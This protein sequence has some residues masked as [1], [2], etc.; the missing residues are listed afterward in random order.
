MGG[1]RWQDFTE[2]QNYVGSCIQSCKTSNS[3]AI[4]QARRYYEIDLPQRRQN[5]LQTLTRYTGW[6]MSKA[7]RFIGEKYR[8]YETPNNNQPNSQPQNS[9]WERLFNKTSNGAKKT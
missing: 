3:N 7:Q 8:V 5:E 2:R 9:W 6:S 4:E 1:G